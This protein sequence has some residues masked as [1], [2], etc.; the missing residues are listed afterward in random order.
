[1]DLRQYLGLRTLKTG[2]AVMLTAMIGLTPLISNPFYAVIGTVFALQNT[3]KSSFLAGKN[4]LLGTVL[5]ALIGYLFALAHLDHPLYLGLAVIITI[6]CCNA[7]K[8]ATSVIIAA[9]VCTSILLG[10]TSDQD[11][12]IYSLLRTTDTSIGIIVGIVVN[13]FIAPPNYLSHV[14]EE[15]IKIEHITLDLVKNILI[16]QDLNIQPLHSELSRLNI[17]FANYCDDTKFHKNRMSTHQLKQSIEACH[18]IYFHAKC[19]EKLELEQTEM[20]LDNK[21][22]IIEFFKLGYQTEIKLSQP[23]DPI[24]EYHIYQMIEQIRLLTS[25]VEDANK[26]LIS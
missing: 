8:I 21:L 5:G 14:T 20:T 17:F 25:T 6:M 23:I 7:L 12:L 11:P 18:D 13:Y 3:V 1:M 16:H 10:I 19:I 9:T 15:I 2:L 24:F 26:H 22:E 4:R